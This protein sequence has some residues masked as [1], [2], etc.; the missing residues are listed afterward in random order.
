MFGIKDRG[1]LTNLPR[2]VS[3]AAVIRACVGAESMLDAFISLGREL[4]AQ[5]R[6]RA[7]GATTRNPHIFFSNKGTREF[8]KKKRRRQR[9]LDP[10]DN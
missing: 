3:P 2:E 5:T 4:Q 7:D 6:C 1:A 9:R 10:K 8:S